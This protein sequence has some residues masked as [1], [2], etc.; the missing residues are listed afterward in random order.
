VN[1]EHPHEQRSHIQ[2]DAELIGE[3]PKAGIRFDPTVNLGH[4][5]TFFGFLV[6]IF[7]AWSTLDKRVIVLEENRRVQMAIDEAQNQRQTQS[8]EQIAS[9]IRDLQRQTERIADKLDSVIENR[10]HSRYSKE[11]AP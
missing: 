1:K 11:S 10:A 7:T 5:I 9:A 2:L 3:S 8:T 4:I 6:A